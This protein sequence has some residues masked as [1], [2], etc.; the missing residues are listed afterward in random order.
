MESRTRIK[1]C[2]ITNAGDAAAA[3]AAGADA[4][5]F[6]FAEQSP[7]KVE[8]E[9]A[10]EVVATLPPF[11]D[12]VGVFVNEDPSVV[13]EIAQYCGLS[14]V[15]LHGRESADY[16]RGLGVRSII[17]TF[18]IHNGTDGGQFAAYAG[19]AQGFLLDTYHEKMAGGSG[20]VFDW[21]LV[22]GFDIPG[23]VILAGGLSP[24]NVYD[25]VMRVRPFAVDANSGVEREPGLK[26]PERIR[27]LA[28]EVRRADADMRR[29]GG[30]Q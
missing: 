8:V 13:K 25:A 14:M 11:V 7:R 1:I 28:A 30:G 4:L 10:R 21:N 24:D 16:C 17:K 15:Q 9:T 3:V 2:G 5:G 18:A 23:P 6:I 19:A 26:D 22:E 29:E 12:A 20:K 27:A